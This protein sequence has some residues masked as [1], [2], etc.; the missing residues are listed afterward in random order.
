MVQSY[1]KILTYASKSQE[2]FSFFSPFYKQISMSKIF[3]P[4]LCRAQLFIWYL[5]RVYY[6]FP[7]HFRDHLATILNV[8]IGFL[9]HFTLLVPFRTK[10]V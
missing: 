6:V 1:K 4:S 3:C 10:L 9:S 7:F 8:T 2:K 5:Y